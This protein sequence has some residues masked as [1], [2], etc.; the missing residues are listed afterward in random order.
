MK[1]KDLIKIINEEFDYLNADELSERDEFID[2]LKEEFFQKQFI[3]DSISSMGDKVKIENVDFSYDIIN[4]DKI[5]L[6]YSSTV[7]Y[8]YNGKDLDFN[9]NIGDS[10]LFEIALNKKQLLR[11]TVENF[12]VDWSN[13]NVKLF[14]LDYEY[15]PFKAYK[16]ESPEVREEFVKAY[17]E[18]LVNNADPTMISDETP[19]N[20]PPIY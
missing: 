3:I 2:L 10:N 18:D 4:D 19:Y 20:S 7:N 15:I 6:S 14:T 12:K 16:N 9:I 13:Y 8:K 11:E 5:K 1:K 17:L